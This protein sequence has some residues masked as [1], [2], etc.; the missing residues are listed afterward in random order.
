MK[1]KE[2]TEQLEL[3]EKER[4]KIDRRTGMRLT[5]F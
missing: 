3:E 4:K 5:A 1:K 2:P